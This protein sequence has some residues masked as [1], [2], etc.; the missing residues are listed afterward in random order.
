[1][2]LLLDTH[3]WLWLLEQPERIAVGAFAQIEAATELVV[4]PQSSFG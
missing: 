2:N 4:Y 1:M 3:I